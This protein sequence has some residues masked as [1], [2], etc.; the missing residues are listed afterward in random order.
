MTDAPAFVEKGGCGPMRTCLAETSLAGQALG[1][2]FRVPN[3]LVF[4]CPCLESTS[5]NTPPLTALRSASQTLEVD[6]VYDLVGK[7]QQVNDPMGTY[8]FVLTAQRAVRESWIRLCRRRQI[9]RSFPCVRETGSWLRHLDRIAY[10]S[11]QLAFAR[12]LQRVAHCAKGAKKPWH[13]TR[14]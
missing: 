8:A 13:R 14:R 9:R 1:M 3:P 11:P 6:Y 12:P 2:I 5:C 7:I 4:K 10:R